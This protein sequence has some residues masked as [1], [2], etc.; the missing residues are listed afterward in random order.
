MSVVLL[1]VVG[2]CACVMWAS[3]GG[4]P[5]SRAVA[6]ATLAAGEPVRASGRSGGN[7]GRGGDADD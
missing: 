5:W 1:V 2:G 6:R 7:R 3:R 4:P